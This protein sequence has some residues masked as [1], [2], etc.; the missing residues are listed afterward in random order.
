MVVADL[1][2]QLQEAATA[3][4]A[5]IDGL[6]AGAD[7]ERAR[8]EKFRRELEEVRRQLGD[9][10]SSLRRQLQ[11]AATAR[12]TAAATITDLQGKLRGAATAVTTAADAERA[13][14]KGFGIEV[15]EVRRQ[16]AAE[17]R[18]AADLRERL[19][20]AVREAAEARLAAVAEVR[21]QLAAEQRGAADMR[22]KLVT[23]VREAAEAR[24]AAAEATARVNQLE[25]TVEA[26]RRVVNQGYTGGNLAIPGNG[27]CRNLAMDYGIESHGPSGSYGRAERQGLCRAI[28]SSTGRPCPNPGAY[29]GYCGI[30]AHQRQRC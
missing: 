25:S 29:G 4:A 23:A 28:C 13:R 3:S 12:T 5:T 27:G 22:E 15:A 30:G 11:E 1:R 18:G 14:A 9:E 21:R 24:R 6:R 17:Q 7:A 10:R 16:L 26:Q 8:V 19:A 20:T 2:Q